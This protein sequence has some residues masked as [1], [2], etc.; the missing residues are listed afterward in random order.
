[1]KKIFR[2][3]LL[4]RSHLKGALS[5]RAILTEALMVS[6]TGAAYLSHSGSQ[7]ETA[8]VRA[9]KLEGFKIRQLV[10]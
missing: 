6:L 7:K 4:N 5:K 3:F 10:S 9:C 1:M 2:R 8:K